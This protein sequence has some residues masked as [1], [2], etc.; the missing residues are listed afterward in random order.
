MSRLDDLVDTFELLDDWEQRYSYIIELGEKL[1]AMPPHLMVDRNNVKGC[2]STVYVSAHWNAD[3][4]GLIQ[5]YGD[6]D[7]SIIR[8]VLA[9]L[10]QLTTDKTAGE[11]EALDMDELFTRLHLDEHLSPFR[12][13]GVY[14]IVALMKQQAKE[15]DEA[16]RDTVCM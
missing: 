3:E 15:L 10:I 8:G 4:P 5:F 14:G 1:P 7:T 6:C 2:M 11:I 12:H 13:V 16:F 9:I